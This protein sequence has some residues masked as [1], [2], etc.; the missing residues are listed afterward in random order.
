MIL[1]V[2]K[3]IA[4]IRFDYVCVP[5]LRK[6]CHM[7]FKTTYVMRIVSQKKEGVK[8][9]LYMQEFFAELL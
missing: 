1:Q 5:I 9:K 8:S 4:N 2:A 6:P 3:R 7:V